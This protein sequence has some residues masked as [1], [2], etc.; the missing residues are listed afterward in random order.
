[1]KA[2]HLHLQQSLF[3]LW[4]YWVMRGTDSDDIIVTAIAYFFF[5]ATVICWCLALVTRWLE[6]VYEPTS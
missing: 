3:Y 6:N 1:M 5:I 4:L 2:S